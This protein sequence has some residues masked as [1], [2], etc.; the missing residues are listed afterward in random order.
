MRLAELIDGIET[1][2]AV[3]GGETTIADLAEDSRLATPGAL[4][5]ARPGYETHGG[6]FIADALARG[7]AAVLT[8]E[9]TPV[10]AGVPVARVRDVTGAAARIAER[11]FGE[12]SGS[13]AVAAVTGTNGKTTTAHLIQ[14]IVGLAGVRCGLLGTVHVDDGCERAPARL[15]TPGTVE[16][17]RTLARMAANGCGACAMEASSH[18]LDQRRLEAVRVRAAVFTN[19]TGDHLDYHG[20]MEAYAAAKA[21]LFESLGADSAAIVNIDDPHARRMTR[22]TRAKAVRCSLRDPA[23]DVFVRSESH[24]ARGAIVHVRGPWGDLSGTYELLGI[25]NLMNLAEAMAAAHAIGV[26]VR[27]L[28]GRLGELEAP[29]GRLEPVRVAPAGVEP[30][31]L[32]DYAHTDDALASALAAVR[33]IVPAG[34]RLWVV[35]GCGGDRDATKRSRMG[36]VATLGADRV[37]VTSD[38]PRTEDPESIIEMILSGVASRAGVEVEAIADRREAITHAVEHS[39]PRDVVLIAGK[40]HEDYQIVPDGSGGVIRRDFDDRLVARDALE[41]RHAAM[42]AAS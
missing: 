27:S 8:D 2:G 18:A 42:A 25:H 29:P 35:F 28:D 12:P 38:N 20:S 32:V 3:I 13:L 40:G 37:V 10:P 34:G 31:V 9:S 15:T 11:F 26:D 33:P 19:L 6:R 16:I 23:T 17:S 41:R 14:Q 4:F 1:T 24:S 30:T 7:S 21:I 36:A 22:G 39:D 5:I